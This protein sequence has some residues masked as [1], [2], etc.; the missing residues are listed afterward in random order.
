MDYEVFEPNDEKLAEIIVRILEKRG[1]DAGYK[2]SYPQHTICIKVNSKEEADK[3]SEIIKNFMKKFKR[4]ESGITT[5][6]LDASI[7]RLSR[8]IPETPKKKRGNLVEN[9]KR[10]IENEDN[11]N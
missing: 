7:T 9:I 4:I 1:Y 8:L 10:K 11:E 2:R 5:Y 6:R 3:I